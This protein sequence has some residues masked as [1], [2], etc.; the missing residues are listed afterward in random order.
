M[1]DISMLCLVFGESPLRDDQLEAPLLLRAGEGR[2]GRMGAKRP[3]QVR[4][5]R[6]L[7][8]VAGAAKKN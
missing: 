1:I 8:S 2:A 5:G 7:R 6:V 3:R 4:E